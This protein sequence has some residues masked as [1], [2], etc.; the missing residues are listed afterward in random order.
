[1]SARMIGV[2]FAAAAALAGC[3]GGASGTSTAKGGA[4]AA[5][6]AGGGLAIVASDASVATGGTF[7]VDVVALSPVPNVFGGGFD[8][9]YDPALLEFVSAD[10]SASALHG[11]VDQVALRNQ[12]PGAVVFARSKQGQV[13]GEDVQGLLARFTFRARA[14]GQ[15]RIAMADLGLVDGAGTDMYLMTP[16]GVNVAV[17]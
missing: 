11:A 12:T 3:G 14:A 6:A 9:R 2:V 1:M 8:L 13:A 7:T 17:R 5:S 10:T 15:A 16:A 4:A